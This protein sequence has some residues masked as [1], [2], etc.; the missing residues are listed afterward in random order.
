MSDKSISIIDSQPNF[1]DVTNRFIDH[2][3]SLSTSLPMVMGIISLTGSKSLKTHQEFLKKNGEKKEG[4]DGSTYYMI[5]P[6]NQR[7]NKVLRREVTKSN[8][9]MKIVERN[10]LVSLVSQF[11]VF[12]GDL[13]RTMYYVRPEL[14]N[15]SDK[16]LTFSNLMDFGDVETAREYII[17]KEIESVLRESHSEQFKWLERKLNIK[18][19]KDLPIWPV[20]IEITQRRNLYVHND[21]TVSNQYLK[22]CKDHKVNLEDDTKVGDSLS[23]NKEYFTL[24]F[25]CIFEIGIKL[26][27]V[28]WRNLT[29]KDI[30]KA[31]YGLLDVSYELLYNEQYSLSKTI[32]DFKEKY[33]KCS[34]NDLDLRLMVN[35]ALTYKWMGEEKLCR[36]I[37]DS[38]DWTATSD[39]FKLAKQVLLEEYELA[40]ETMKV[41]ATHG[42]EIDQIAY[43]E[44]PIFK[45]FRKQESFQKAFDELYEESYKVKERIAESGFK[46]ISEL[47]FHTQLDKCLNIAKSKS[48]G[49]VGSKF[50]IE[51]HLAK[52]GYDIGNCWELYNKLEKGKEIKTYIHKDPQGVFR[53]INA[54]VKKDV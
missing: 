2:I 19:T 1:S 14:L 50:F 8:I 29:P 9:A 12:V 45:E 25:E 5:K 48:G 26:S 54:I 31:D 23:M 46:I 27:Q 13:I 33:V 24:A 42:N 11:D 32:L 21:G 51:T 37:V 30:E 22:V 40:V 18:L 28:M 53:D 35:R 15:S 38:K 39:I 34:S 17:E 4:D 52:M 47:D 10:F 6:E 20:F 41:L 3:E 16:Q 49:F 44:W 7:R 36:E 43:R